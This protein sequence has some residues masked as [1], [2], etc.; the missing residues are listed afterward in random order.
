MPVNAQQTEKISPVGPEGVE[1][2]A[3]STVAGAGDAV[4]RTGAAAGHVGRNHLE[5][6][7]THPEAG[8]SVAEDADVVSPTIEVGHKH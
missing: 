5:E 7:N 4:E 6:G 1:S 3:Q 8:G 2:V